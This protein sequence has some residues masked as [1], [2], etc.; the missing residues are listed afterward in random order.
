MKN[1]RLSRNK[2]ILYCYLFELSAWRGYSILDYSSEVIPKHQCLEML[3][4]IALI[5]RN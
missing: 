1:L 4:F 5:R 2:E 3:D